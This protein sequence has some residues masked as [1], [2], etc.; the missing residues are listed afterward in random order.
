MAARSET[1]GELFT[2]LVPDYKGR[3]WRNFVE[4]FRWDA[5]IADYME[6]VS[7]RRAE[8]RLRAYII[9]GELESGRTGLRFGHEK[10]G[11][12]YR[13]DRKDFCLL[14]A[15]YY[16]GNLHVFYRRVELI[17]G[18]HYDTILFRE[19]ERVTGWDIRRITIM[20]AEA[21]VFA[22]SGNSNEKLYKK[23]KAHYAKA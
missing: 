19:I 10:V 13:G 11:H 2:R 4:T 20:A 14:A 8:S 21:K 5:D 22:L 23:L 7:A 1:I 6:S 17:G 16:K 3:G 12:G 15:S 9:K 18:L